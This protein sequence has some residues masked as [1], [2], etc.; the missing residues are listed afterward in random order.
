MEEERKER[1]TRFERMKG[2]FIDVCKKYGFYQQIENKKLFFLFSLRLGIAANK[3]F[4]E[5]Q[6]TEPDKLELAESLLFLWK[7]QHS[8]IKLNGTFQNKGE[9]ILIRNR[10]TIF[11]L[12]MYVNKALSDASEGFYEDMFDWE[13]KKHLTIKIYD[14]DQKGIYYKDDT[15]FVESYTKEELDTIIQYEKKKLRI[16]KMATKAKHG[17]ELYFLNY[18]MLEA[19][20]FRGRKFHEYGFL[21]DYFAILGKGEKFD[22]DNLKENSGEVLR[23]KYNEIRY[24]LKANDTAQKRKIGENWEEL[25]DQRMKSNREPQNLMK[26][27]KGE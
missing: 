13:Y 3:E 17:K 15:C 21:Y 1:E 8:K 23:E 25:F 2:Q 9:D 18:K 14:P 5:K 7:C 22:P 10:G 4:Y 27:S 24:C 16:R 11:Y 26:R 6:N 20:I 12:M 19:G